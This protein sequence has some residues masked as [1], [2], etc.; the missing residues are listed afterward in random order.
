MAITPAATGSVIATSGRRRPQERRTLAPARLYAPAVTTCAHRVPGRRRAPALAVLV[1]LATPV[2]PAAADDI[3]EIDGRLQDAG[4]ELAYT[5]AVDAADR[6]GVR[7]A[8]DFDSGS[9][10]EAAFSSEAARAA[11]LVWDHLEGRV[12]A[13]DVASTYDVP[14]AED[15]LP[16]ALSFDRAELTERFGARPDGLDAADVETFDDSGLAIVGGVVAAWLLSLV[17]VGVV[18]FFVAR[19]VYRRP[20]PAQWG[21]GTWPGPHGAAPQPAAWPPA[22]A[23]PPA[24]PARPGEPAR[25]QAPDDPWRPLG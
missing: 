4:L 22:P 11:E 10:D 14:W 25:Q 16:S 3:F 15:G 8:V 12:L 17:V 24:P 9:Q 2:T 18:T 5:V 7:V 19:A 20:P 23:A 1:L 6:P 13:V 21:V